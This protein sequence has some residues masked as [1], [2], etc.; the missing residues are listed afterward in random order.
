VLA[1]GGRA[2]ARG[3][4]ALGGLGE[5]LMERK[6]DES[7]REAA[8]AWEIEQ[9]RLGNGHT[10]ASTGER[11]RGIGAYGAG[12]P[13]QTEA[14]TK[15]IT[16]WRDNPDG[17]YAR[18]SARARKR[19]DLRFLPE[20][21]RILT[22]A[23]RRDVET[24]D[25]AAR[26]RDEAGLA[27]AARTAQAYA[28]EP[29]LFEA[30]AADYAERAARLK[31]GRMI[32]NPEEADPSKLVFRDDARGSDGKPSGSARTLY[33]AARAEALERMRLE[34]VRTL[35]AD[36]RTAEADADAEGRFAAA[37]SAAEILPPAM[38]AEIKERAASAR[39][40]RRAAAAARDADAAAARREAHEALRGEAGQIAFDF[41]QG[42]LSAEDALKGLDALNVRGLAGADA[43]SAFDDVI[44]LEGARRKAAAN[45]AGAGGS[46]PEES[47]MAVYADLL[48]RT[49]G[50]EDP[51]I[52]LGDANAAWAAGKLAKADYKYFVEHNGRAASAERRAAVMGV[53]A[54]AAGFTP[55]RAEAAVKGATQAA[56]ED[57]GKLLD[58]FEVR[59]PGAWFRSEMTP[60]E[61]GRMVDGAE[62]WLRANPGKG[63]EDL[64]REYIDPLLNPVKARAAAMDGLR[65]M[66]AA[67]GREE[68]GD[69]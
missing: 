33:A 43:A 10:D 60:A 7:L 67:L 39:A 8:A 63:A 13:S 25:A 59:K 62:R 53:L 45:L 5:R 50:G 48:A 69:E 1:E 18:M 65:G 11:V 12:D 66:D 6:E 4:A 22:L 61:F 15:G 26:M 14:W 38:Q 42:R 16:A 52:A 30:A 17:P 64:R 57:L 21:N 58:A 23:S 46:P 40:Y 44:R 49:V 47:D 54:G 35:V 31:A 51:A 3:V 2:L 68:D 29:D 24:Q 56:R 36:G 41:R 28:Y 20:T 37:L 32:A 55:E 9:D 27:A 19:F 34:R